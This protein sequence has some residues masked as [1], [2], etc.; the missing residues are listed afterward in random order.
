MF[1]KTGKSSKEILSYQKYLITDINGHIASEKK[2][3][4]AYLQSPKRKDCILCQNNLF[5]EDFI[6]NE[7]GYSFCGN[8]G[9]LNGHNQ[10]SEKLMDQTYSEQS[11]D[12]IQ[13]DKHYIQ[14]INEF[15]ATV[16]NIYQPKANFL[17]NAL[18]NDNSST[19][20]NDLSILDFGTGSGHMV[21]ALE[22]VGFNKIHGID[23]METTIKFGREILSIN[24]L[25]RVPVSKSTEYLAQSK[26][27]IVSMICTL[28]HVANHNEILETMK[29]NSS[30]RYTFQK[31]PFFSL[32]ALL[33]VIY[34]EINSRVLSGTHTH[35]YTEKS[36]EYIEKKYGMVRV[37]EW[38]FGADVLD[39][40]RNLQIGI[41]KKNFSNKLSAEVDHNFLPLI[42]EL[43]LVLDKYNYSSEIHVLWKFIR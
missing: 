40:Y 29:N 7:I 2:F 22:K 9:H 33:D 11:I 16:Q 17:M 15:N 25:E 43:Q 8:C 30:I 5:S 10:L 41:S 20:V 32:S 38:R 24:N 34:P 18:L 14:E 36:L 42:D 4:K 31:L 1:K 27:D 28:P 13:Y 21:K 23:P 12:G 39:L 37:G 3:E 6:R 26:S 19:Y 35:I